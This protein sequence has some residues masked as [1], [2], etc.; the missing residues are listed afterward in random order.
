[1]KL[2]SYSTIFFLLSLFLLM[3]LTEQPETID[4]LPQ[5]NTSILK[6]IRL[7]KVILT[8]NHM[9]GIS[10][11]VSYLNPVQNESEVVKERV[12]IGKIVINIPRP[13]FYQFDFISSQL[14]ELKFVEEDLYPSYYALIFIFLTIRVI[15]FINH[16][17]FT[18]LE[19]LV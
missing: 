7:N 5:T 10:L 8:S 1:M 19:D 11:K 15:I 16:N 18:S 3:P 4:I 2:H 14:T 6:N 12:F 17:Y 9:E 13:G